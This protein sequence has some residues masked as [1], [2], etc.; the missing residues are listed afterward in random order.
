MSLECFRDLLAFMTRL[1]LGGG[2][3]EGAARCFHL[4]PLAGLLIAAITYA[5]LLALGLLEAPAILAGFLY[6]AVHYIVTGGLHLDGLADYA[7]VWGS[8]SRGGDALR[9]LKDP[10]R[11]SHAIMAVTVV[12][13]ASVGAFTVIYSIGLLEALAFVAAAYAAA[14][15]SM[16]VTVLVGP[17]EPYR[18]MASPFKASAHRSYGANVMLYLTITLA[19][20]VSTILYKPHLAIPIVGIMTLTPTLGVIVALDARSRLGFVSG[21]VAGASFEVSRVAALT[22]AALAVASI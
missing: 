2:S 19:L 11:G 6:P 13:L 21:D 3:L 16:Y 5:P 4:A 22:M 8:G 1:P 17:P 12:T 10:R 14:Y 9:V 7:D 20:G 18:G 15:E